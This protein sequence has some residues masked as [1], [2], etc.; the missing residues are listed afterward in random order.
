MLLEPVALVLAR[1]FDLK[2]CESLIRNGGTRDEREIDVLQITS[3]GY[4]D[5]AF[6]PRTT[7]QL[8]VSCAGQGEADFWHR[9]DGVYNDLLTLYFDMQDAEEEVNISYN[10]QVM[11]NLTCSRQQRTAVKDS[12]AVSFRDRSL[13]AFTARSAQML[14][15]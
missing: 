13:D 7:E 5:F 8:R 12:K 10:K 9:A 1:L 6:V 2:I 3:V 4:D 14:T 15:E 11:P